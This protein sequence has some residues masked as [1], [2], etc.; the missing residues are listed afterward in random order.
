MINS[1][2]NMEEFRKLNGYSN[3]RIYPDGRI[4]SEFIGRF[5]TPTFDSGKYLQVTLVDDSGV[6]KTVK[7]HRLVASAFI[8]NLNEELEI[9]HKDFDKTNNN[10]SNL[11]WCNRTYNVRY[12]FSERDY[13]KQVEKVSALTKEQ[14]LI[15]PTLIEYGFSIKLISR[16]FNVGHI[17]IRK[18]ISGK[19]WKTL[20]LKFPEKCAFNR[21]T[22]EI[23]KSLY[24][25]LLS[26]GADNTVLNS[27]IKVLESV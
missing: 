6:R 12:N 5:I 19:T 10:V 1:N 26:I 20:N 14:V 2:R 15:I 9:N 18:I 13:T 16:L 21:F 27:R 8:P 23:P 22:I 11:E 17:T 4:Y 7:V 24:H 3:Y 25:K